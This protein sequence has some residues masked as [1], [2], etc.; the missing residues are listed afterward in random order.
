M[1]HRLGIRWVSVVSVAVLGCAGGN[2]SEAEAGDNAANAIVVPDTTP[3][4]PATPTPPPIPGTPSFPVDAWVTRQ[5][6][7]VFAPYYVQDQLYRIQVRAQETLGDDKKPV[8]VTIT[9]ASGKSIHELKGEMKF[10]G[11]SSRNFPKKPYSLSLVDDSGEDQKIGLLGMDEAS[12]FA[13][14]AA[15]NDRSLVRDILTYDL[16]NQS[17]HYAP[18]V[19]ISTMTMKVGDEPEKELGI[20]LLIEKIDIA[21]GK[22][23]IPKDKD[24]KSAYLLN[25]D[26]V[27]DG[28]KFVTTEKGLKVLVDYPKASK[29]RPEQ[30]A[31]IVAFLNDIEA[32]L[33]AP[34]TNGYYTLFSDRIDLE[35]AVSIF[36]TQ[37]L[38]RNVDG[39]RLSSPMYIPPNGKLFF[40]PVWD[41]NLGYGNANY[42][43]GWKTDGWRAAEEGV[44]FKD[45]MNHP[46]FCRELKTKW[47]Q[48]R[49]GYLSNNNIFNVI[50]QNVQVMQPAI[51]DNFNLW[52]IGNYVWP[53]AYWLPTHK[54]E[55]DALKSWISL[56]TEWMDST[57]TQMTC[58][59]PAP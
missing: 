45:L 21:K 3:T 8:E 40:G 33:K 50:D 49:R 11:S 36:I 35:S 5:T 22:V 13:L 19:R 23:A 14:N 39:Y 6:G 43:N 34:Q 2:P 52:G 1:K 27:K 56:R 32:R 12:S 57:I 58:D 7:G 48:V 31:E 55:V 47:K 16:F 15:Y 4:T 26:R 9:D 30:E 29:L 59:Q 25:V 53:N 17:G 38:A 51:D 10:R 42:G 24:G 18:R 54:Q 41:M 20:Y 46:E 28:D 44:W 37:E